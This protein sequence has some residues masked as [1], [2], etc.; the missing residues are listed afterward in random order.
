MT[1]AANLTI[2]K[3]SPPSLD[4]ELAAL[5]RC[6][7]KEL[8][9]RWQELFGIA[10]PDVSDDVLVRA[11][12][13]RLQEQAYGGL[14]ASTS[15][16]LRKI[17]ADLRTNRK[18]V[19]LSDAPKIA[20]GVQLLREW[21]GETEVVEVTTSGFVWRGQTYRSLSAVARAMTG[22]R[23]SGPRFFGLPT[24][25]DRSASAEKGDAV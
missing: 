2:M 15:R 6:G 13:Y 12:A 1:R 20:P 14:S 24:A 25:D 7:L 16:K 21:N 11:I 8:Q 17:A 18:A 9:Q 5:P 19:S 3:P 10:A 22:A 23:W 4:S